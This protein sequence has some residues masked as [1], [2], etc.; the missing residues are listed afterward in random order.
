MINQLLVICSA[1]IIYEYIK[2]VHLIDTIFSQF[3]IFL[4]MLK[5]FNYKKISD[6]RKEKLIFSYSKLLFIGSIKIF[7]ILILIIIFILT[8]NLI[9]SSYLNFIISILGM[10]ELTITFIIYH[11]IRKKFY[12]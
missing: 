3:K 6:F 2:Y 12:E 8:L 11:L 9:F 10:I 7:S 5:L 1:I 4:K